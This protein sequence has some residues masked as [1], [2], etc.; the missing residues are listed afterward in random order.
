MRKYADSEEDPVAAGQELK[1]SSVLEG[2]IQRSGKRMRVTVQLVNVQD[3][4]PLWAGTFDETFT[5]IFAVE[6]SISE[7]V[8][9]ALTL[10]LSKEER[11]R[12]KKRYTDNTEAYQA[13]L[14]GRYFLGK[15]T[16][17]DLDKCVCLLQRGD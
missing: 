12:L 9:S 3:G 13:Y 7:Q 17:A 11:K 14:K 15:R 8:A 10:N 1:V 2:S 4:A 5:N 6:D 16:V